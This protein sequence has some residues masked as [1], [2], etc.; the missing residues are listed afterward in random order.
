MSDFLDDLEH[1]AIIEETKA[2]ERLGLSP[3][4]FT[5]GPVK[6]KTIIWV[7]RDGTHINIQDM[8]YNHLQLSIA[9]CKRDNWRVEAIPYLEAELISRNT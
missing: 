4:W 3:Y 9:K 5:T 2:E 6:K 8:T 1:Q 7:T